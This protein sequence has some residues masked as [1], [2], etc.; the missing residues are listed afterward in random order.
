MEE[1]RDDL[2]E[3]ENM[4]DAWYTMPPLSPSLIFGVLRQG[5]KMILTGPSKAGKSYA[6]IELCVAIAEGRPWMG[7][8]CAVGRVLYVNL[9]LERSSCLHRFEAV[10]RAMGLDPS[11][12]DRLDVWNLRGH[13]MPMERLAAEIINRGGGKDYMAVVIDPV[14]KVME[15]GENSAEDTAE[16][17]NQL[18]RICSALQCS[19]IYCHHHSKGRQ[20]WKA[21]MDRGSGSGVFSRDADAILDMIELPVD[22]ETRRRRATAASLRV[23]EAAIR[24]A[25]EEPG[26]YDTLEEALEACRGAMW[27]QVYQE[28]IEAAE[29][30]RKAAERRTAWRIEGTL[31]EFPQFPPVNLWFDFPVHRLDST[32]VL[33]DIDPEGETAAPGWKRAMSKRKPKAQKMQERQGSIETAYEACGI[34]GKVTVQGMAEYLGVSEKT[35][36]RRL[37]EH[38]GFWIDGGTVGRK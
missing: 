4:A 20:D 23:C 13:S 17:C 27:S 19:V 15:G 22:E 3:P 16:F 7:F 33:S 14:Y 12:I 21:S 28:T 36:R 1:R 34:D 30:A 26:H 18:D 5:G 9:E 37:Q 2:P 6:L 29:T 24:D 31:R 38:G 11:H 32:G 35:V 8:P 25:G 10:Y